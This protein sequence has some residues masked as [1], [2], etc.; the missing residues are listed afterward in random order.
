M[1]ETALDG[2]LSMDMGEKVVVVPGV[3]DVGAALQ[4]FKWPDYVMFVVMLLICVAIGIYFGIYRGV[5]NAQE[6]LMG[7]RK[8]KIFPITMS[9]VAR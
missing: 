5:A 1:A 6:Y 2:M 3:A 4:R 7:N 8:M 9:L